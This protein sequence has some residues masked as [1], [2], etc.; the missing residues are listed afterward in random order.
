MYMRRVVVLVACYTSLCT[1]C[2]TA[3]CTSR[4]Y[5]DPGWMYAHN[6]SE[7]YRVFMPQWPHDGLVENQLP[8]TQLRHDR[9]DE[10]CRFRVGQQVGGWAR[11]TVG[12]RGWA[13]CGGGEANVTALLPS[14]APA[15]ARLPVGG[16]RKRQRL[17][18]PPASQVQQAT[19][20]LTSH[21]RAGG[22][23]GATVPWGLR[24]HSHAV[25]R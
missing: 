4:R 2:C 11:R 9:C 22:V 19:G 20:P 24:L 7:E 8:F 15:G 21:A 3:C 12:R 14:G 1:A 10:V 25:V 17:A 5:T 13:G 18:R 16:R 6:N 23:V